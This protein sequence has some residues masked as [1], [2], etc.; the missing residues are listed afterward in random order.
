MS[1]GGEVPVFGDG[2]TERDYTYVDD[3]VQGGRARSTRP[4]ATWELEVVN[5]GESRTVALAELL[6]AARRGDADRA[7]AACPRSRETWRAPSPASTRRAACWTTTRVPVEEGIRRFVRWLGREGA[8][9][10]DVRRRAQ[11]LVHPRRRRDRDRPPP[12]RAPGARPP[13]EMLCRDAGMA[14]RSAATAYPQACPRGRRRHAPG[15]TS[16]RRVL[17]GSGRTRW[18]SPPSRRCSSPG[19]ARAWRGVPQVVQRI[20]LSTDV[21]RGARYR[22][23]LRRFVDMIALNAEVMRPAFLAA[24]P[25]LD[26]AACAPCTTAC[27]SRR[28]A[29]RGRAP[30]PRPPRWSPAVGAVARL[31]K[32]KRFERLLRAWHCSRRTCTACSRVRGRRE[33]RWKRSRRSSGWRARAFP[34]LPR[35]RR[36]RAGRAGRARG[37]LGQRGD[38]ERD[39]G[40]DGRAS[41]GEHARK[42]RGGGAGAGSRTGGAGADRRPG[43]RGD[44]GSAARDRSTIPRRLAEMSAAARERV[45]ERFSFEGCSTAGSG[46]WRSA[47]EPR[48]QGGHVHGQPLGA[49]QRAAEP[50]ARGGAAGAPPPARRLVPAR[51]APCATPSPRWGYPPRPPARAATR[52]PWSAARF[53]A[54]LRRERPDAALMTSWVPRLGAGWAARAAGVPRVV[55]G[56]GEV[57]AMPRDRRVGVPAR[58]RPLHRG[59]G[60]QLARHAGPL[61]GANRYHRR[62]CTTCPTASACAPPPRRP[63]RATGDPRGRALV[64]GISRLERRKATTCCG[65]ARADRRS[66]ACTWWWPRRRRRGARCG[67]GRSRWASR[68][69]CACW[70]SAPTSARCSRPATCSC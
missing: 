51:R 33:Q 34:R 57:H 32:Q 5:L 59:H 18:C 26:P 3:I 8:A 6:G 45:E 29:G 13:G 2:T 39:A 44:R 42:R 53:V 64:A 15:R 50:A 37:L 27:A 63:S 12:G 36:R 35:R 10:P 55:L 11:R 62:Q 28:R 25:E 49:R 41:R 22:L 43:A 60:R 24:D 31:A 66:R 68:T 20:V 47:H 9:P 21:P 40:G 23:A 61:P 67:R 69:A 14:E 46:C 56:I 70:G 4:L 30:R 48:P 7:S 65:R 16:L 38:G 58:P 17:G 1:E 19:W 52:D 54:W